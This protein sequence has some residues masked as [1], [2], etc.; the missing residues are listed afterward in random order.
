MSQ[1]HLVSE[2]RGIQQNPKETNYE[3]LQ[4]FT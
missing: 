3:T 1:L 4:T 2:C